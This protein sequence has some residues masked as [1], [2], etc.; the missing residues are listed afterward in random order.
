MRAAAAFVFMGL[1][2]ATSSALADVVFDAPF[3]GS[4]TDT[5]GAA[6]STLSG[7]P[8]FSANVP[9][10]Q[11]PLTGVAD[12]QS[13]YLSSGSSIIVNSAFPFDT[14]ANATLQFYV[15]PNSI[16]SEQDLFWTTGAGGDANRYNISIDASGEI[17]MDYRSADGT[18]HSIGGTAPGTIAAGVWTAVAIVKQGDT[19]T[20]YIN[21]VDA[22]SG[23]DNSPN[24]PTSTEWTINGRGPLNSTCCEFS[25]YVDNVVIDNTALTPNQ[26]QSFVPEPASLAVFGVGVWGLR[27]VRRTKAGRRIS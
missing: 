15:D 22:G 13:L 5:Q 25:G 14:S 17:G 6:I 2:I 9:A 21:G 4:L 8:T 18:L 7:T 11:I 10:A 26:F 23:T 24:L 3:E 16:G 12:T 1:S 27:R 19:Y 20:I